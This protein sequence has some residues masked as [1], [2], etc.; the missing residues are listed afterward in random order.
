MYI[1][2]L[3]SE[4]EVI[5]SAYAFTLEEVRTIAR[6]WKPRNRLLVYWAQ[7][8]RKKTM[9]T[10]GGQGIA[11]FAVKPND[12]W[13]NWPSAYIYVT[14]DPDTVDRHFERMARKRDQRKDAS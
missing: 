6:R 12:R 8:P 10:E 3:Q 5:N 11:E 1:L 7:A 2:E 9:L 4:N 13:A 14:C